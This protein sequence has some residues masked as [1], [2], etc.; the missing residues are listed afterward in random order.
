MQKKSFSLL[1]IAGALMLF[2]ASCSSISVTSDFD[3]TVDFTKFKTYEYYGWADESDK[4]LN[5]LDK[6]RIEKAFGEEFSKRGMEYVESGGDLVVTL[7]IVVQQKTEQRATTTGTGGYGGYYGGYYGYGPGW[8][9]GPSYSTTTVS[10]YDYNVGTL[11]VDVFDKANEQLI[12]ESA[13]QGTIDENPQNRDKTIPKAVAKIMAT[14]PVPPIP[15]K[16][17]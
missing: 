9:W 15:E 6:K 4:I 3:N 8:G 13:G 17:K 16:K 14:Y 5:D 11:V 2:L 1:F 10:T 7:F 12:W